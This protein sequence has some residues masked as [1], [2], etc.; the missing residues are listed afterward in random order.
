MSVGRQERVIDRLVD[1][2]L[3]D[4]EEVDELRSSHGDD[5]TAAL[6]AETDLGEETLLQH[7]AL[8]YELP[9]AGYSEGLFIERTL[10]ERID[11][12][13]I[14][15]Y[16]IFPVRQHGDE[17]VDIVTV[18][19]LNDLAIQVLEEQLELPVRQYIWPRL[20]F[21]QALHFFLGDDI[22]DWTR[23]YL[24]ER[25]VS[26]GYASVEND[27]DVQMALQSS[28]S[29]HVLQWDRS[30]VRYFIESCFDRDTLLKVLL[31]YAGHWL[32]SRLIVVF[33]KKGI[34]PY[35]VEEWP[36]LETHYDDVQQLRDICVDISSKI[37]AGKSWE[38][39]DVESLGIASLFEAMEIDPPSF[40]VAIPV[41]IG[42]R[43]AMSIIGVPTDRDTALRLD[44]EFIDRFEVEGLEKAARWVGA[45]LQNMIKLAKKGAL[46]PPADRIPPL[47]RPDQQF[48][49]GV[50]ESLIEQTIARR[51]D[52]DKPRHRWEIVDISEVIED[53]PD[54]DESHASPDDVSAGDDFSDAAESAVPSL[55]NIESVEESEGT[56]EPSSPSVA[57]TSFGMPA[58]SDMELDDLSG[59]NF[60]PDV[61][62]TSYGMPSLGDMDD[63]E[64]ILSDNGENTEGTT[65]KEPSTSASTE[66]SEEKDGDKNEIGAEDSDTLLPDASSDVEEESAK[67]EQSRHS[68]QVT[69]F[70]AA[71][72]SELSDSE[73]VME[74]T[75]SSDVLVSEPG[76]EEELSSPDDD[77]D[78]DDAP[79]TAENFAADLSASPTDDDH[80]LSEDQESEATDSQKLST[81]SD[82]AATKTSGAKQ[83][84]SQDDSVPRTATG[85]TGLQIPASPSGIPMAQILRR[86]RRKSN[87]AEEPAAAIDSTSSSGDNSFEDGDSVTGST[88]MGVGEVL[89][90]G[91]LGG[92][93]ED[94]GETE[95]EVQTLERRSEPRPG[96]TVNLGGT[97]SSTQSFGELIED[98]AP[99]LSS[100]SPSPF[101]HRP[102]TIP[103]DVIEEISETGP[104]AVDLEPSLALI[105]DADPKKAF[106]AA[107]HLATAGPSILPALESLFPGRLFVDRYQYT[108]DTLP[109]VNE[110]GPVL[111]ALV[112]IGEP[113]LGLVETFL[114]HSSVEYRFYA[115]FLLTELPAE[116]LLPKIRDQLFDRDRQTRLVARKIVISHRHVEEFDS[117]ILTP[118]RRIL[119]ESDEDLRLEVAADILRHF[120]DVIAIPLLIDALEGASDHLRKTLHR[121]LRQITYQ[122][123][124]PSPTEWRRWWKNCDHDKRWK[125]L[126]QAMNSDDHD[127]RLLAFD[128]IEQIPGLELD[129]HPDQPK[130][131][132]ARAQE[133]LTKFFEAQ[134]R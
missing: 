104:K 23:A 118:L 26:L 2:G 66:E 94:V 87:S 116:N 58:L 80:N 65:R 90:L 61:A 48:G 128:E 11:P 8:C 21:L 68:H 102:Q 88:M 99:D 110:H 73:P 5:A 6:P 108:A 47:P 63:S 3:V 93:S 106:A 84:D 37:L 36:E 129:F 111:E 50:E 54:E 10:L 97:T 76:P 38:S 79:S 89:H 71:E 46:P 29:L 74:K 117:L 119:E 57:A 27:I 40:L 9:P 20:R 53:S 70:P 123:L 19:P 35:F 98:M 1:E 81:E 33:G 130:K 77:D 120:K 105:E 72:S 100:N 67:D 13:I 124:A 31:G 32:T 56:S 115:T 107:E 134:D 44:G 17:R 103:M 60:P 122:R 34:Q 59:E 82:A 42:P 24:Y 45:Q 96:G 92:D 43:T 14:R 4:A 12:E 75:P 7:L 121:A 55:G 25:P 83:Q 39:G 114:D 112:R 85:A 22:P 91:S 125:W 78:D 86:P 62:A 15:K 131:L 51:H 69:P 28:T 49:L 101:E 30:D 126:V 18:E 133:E 113:S 109:A 52:D 95:S 64:E 16:E 41:R 127:I 132:R